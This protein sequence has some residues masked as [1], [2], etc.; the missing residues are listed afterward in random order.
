MTYAN[1][2]KSRDFHVESMLKVI[3][4]ATTSVAAIPADHKVFNE[5]TNRDCMVQGLATQ[6][7]QSYPCRNKNAHK[8]R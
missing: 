7:I 4:Q 5:K 6:K 3:P 2:R 1:A 8:I